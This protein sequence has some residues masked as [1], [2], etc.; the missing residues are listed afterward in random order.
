MTDLLLPSSPRP[1]DAAEDCSA[2]LDGAVDRET[3]GLL[4]R[5]L[6]RDPELRR[7]FA[8]YALIGSALKG[9]LTDLGLDARFAE[10]VTARLP[11]KPVRRAEPF[12]RRGLPWVLAG[13]LAVAVFTTFV[14]RGLVVLPPLGLGAGARPAA[15]AAAPGHEVRL[16]SYGAPGRATWRHGP[17]AERRVLDEYLLTHLAAPGYAPVMVHA[18]LA[19]YEVTLAAREP[20]AGRP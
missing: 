11:P 8:R 17:A 10:S 5:R 15:G 6:G 2:L 19:T 13:G 18:R 9:Q 4:L 20:H 12:G 7:R 16:A 3:T 1:P 14:I